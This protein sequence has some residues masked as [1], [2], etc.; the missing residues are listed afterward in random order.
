MSAALQRSLQYERK[1]SCLGEKT[2]RTK[3]ERWRPATA[4]GSTS[5]SQ[6]TPSKYKNIDLKK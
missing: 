5:S 4:G 2:N 1:L 6:P 3:V